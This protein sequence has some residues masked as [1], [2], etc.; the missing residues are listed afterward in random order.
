MLSFLDILKI[1]Q[2]IEL[3]QKEEVSSTV[4]KH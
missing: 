4:P 1:Q 3:A 2:P